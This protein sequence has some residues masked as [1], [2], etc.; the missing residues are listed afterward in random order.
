MLRVVEGGLRIPAPVEEVVGDDHRQPGSDPV[1]DQ[2]QEVLVF[3]SGSDVG[4]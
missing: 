2:E 4:L 1:G 3:G